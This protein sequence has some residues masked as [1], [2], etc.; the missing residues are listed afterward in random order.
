M[1]VEN[2][3]YKGKKF[4]ALRRT[5]QW[6]TRGDGNPAHKFIPVKV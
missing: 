5:T 1:T 4:F 2:I 3:R 6:T